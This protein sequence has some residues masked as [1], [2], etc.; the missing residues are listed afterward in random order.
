MF[1]GLK[2]KR[3][4]F[5]QSSFTPCE[6]DCF[7]LK[8][9]KYFRFKCFRR[10]SENKFQKLTTCSIDFLLFFIEIEIKKANEN[11]IN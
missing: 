3:C 10:F 9:L 1:D 8:T 2:L 6:H 11:H 7:C 4:K 5:L